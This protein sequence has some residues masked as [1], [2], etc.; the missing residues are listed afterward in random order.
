MEGN[1]IASNFGDTTSICM[2]FSEERNHINM[3][4]LSGFLPICFTYPGNE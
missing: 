2:G 1:I 4:S 3:R